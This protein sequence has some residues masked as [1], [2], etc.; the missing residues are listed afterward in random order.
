MSHIAGVAPVSL[1]AAPLGVR[2]RI[3]SARNSPSKALRAE[4]GTANAATSRLPS[5]ALRLMIGMEQSHR[6]ALF[7]RLLE[8]ESCQPAFNR[9]PQIVSSVTKN[10]ASNMQSSR[11]LSPELNMAIVAIEGTFCFSE[12]PL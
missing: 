7:L 3:R 1:L 5:K 9:G 2:T 10:L 6:L 11:G 4:V 8:H 12:G